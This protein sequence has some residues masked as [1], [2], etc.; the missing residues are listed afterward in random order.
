[1]FS[2]FVGALFGEGDDVLFLTAGLPLPLGPPLDDVG[3]YYY[4]SG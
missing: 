4:I 2:Y 3:Y 1:M